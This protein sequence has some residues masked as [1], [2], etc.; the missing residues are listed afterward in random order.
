M[1]KCP[2]NSGDDTIQPIWNSGRDSECRCV[3]PNKSNQPSNINFIQ[4]PRKLGSEKVCINQT[5]FD[6]LLELALS[7][8][9]K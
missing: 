8:C 2:C 5:N 7:N 4:I 6:K 9:N 1:R 3:C